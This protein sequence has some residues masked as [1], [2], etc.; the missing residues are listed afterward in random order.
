MALAAPPTSLAGGP[1]KLHHLLC[2]GIKTTR[3]ASQHLQQRFSLDPA[4]HELGQADWS[5]APVIPDA[6][7]RDSLHVGWFRAGWHQST[8]APTLPR[9]PALARHWHDGPRLT[10]SACQSA[11]RFAAAAA[12]ASY[13]CAPSTLLLGPDGRAGWSARLQPEPAEAPTPSAFLAP[14]GPLS[15]L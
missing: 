9:S 15:V 12:R 1:V 5:G 2:A 10:H 14:R 3:F 7:V 11:W 4:I 13:S 8:R 6:T